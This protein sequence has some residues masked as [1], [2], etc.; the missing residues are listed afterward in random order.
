MVIFVRR[1]FAVV[2]GAAS[3]LVFLSL[4]AVAGVMSAS[5]LA[6][7][8]AHTGKLRAENV[9]FEVQNI[10]GDWTAVLLIS[11]IGLAMAVIVHS[12]R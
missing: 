1:R 11:N 8:R 5:R 9:T 2:V 3:A 6:D 10:A 7:V 4:F 12:R